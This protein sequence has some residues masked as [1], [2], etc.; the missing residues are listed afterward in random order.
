M[1][2]VQ[3]IGAT[4]LAVA[5]SIPRAV[6]AQAPAA[7]PALVVLIA[8]DQ[9]RG[10]YLD[11]FG[12]QLTGGL[13]R[14]RAQSALFTHAWQDHAITETAP[15]H[16]TLLSGREPAHTTIVDNTYGVYD[17]EMPL[18]G[19]ITG[20]GASPRPMPPERL[21]PRRRQGRRG[22]TDPGCR[23]TPAGL[24]RPKVEGVDTPSS[25]LPPQTVRRD[26]AD[27]RGWGEI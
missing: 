5:P 17:P 9:F 22:R 21:A 18:I 8:I 24:G 15:G 1:K 20:P 23:F 13:A 4:I 2:L 7:R 19:G 16:S 26:L 25:D 12:P 11:R 27:A 6:E 10:D 14:V 3:L